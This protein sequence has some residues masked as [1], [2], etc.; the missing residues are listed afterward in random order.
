MIRQRFAAPAKMY[1]DFALQQVSFLDWLPV[2]CPQSQALTRRAWTTA[3][4]VCVESVYHVS[5]LPCRSKAKTQME[6]NL[7]KGGYGQMLTPARQNALYPG[8]IVPMIEEV[9]KNGKH[10]LD[11]KAAKKW[12]QCHPADVPGEMQVRLH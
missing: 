8:N 10:E 12:L 11:T 4:P 3:E 2:Y 9:S 6:A 7:K 1:G 5:W